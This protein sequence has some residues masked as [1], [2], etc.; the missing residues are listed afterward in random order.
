M[1]T[2]SAVVEVYVCFLEELFNSTKD[3]FIKVVV[4]VVVKPIQL[5][6][7]F[8]FSIFLEV[9]PDSMRCGAFH[10]SF[11]DIL[12]C[13]F[14]VP[15]VKS[16][17][18]INVCIL[19]TTLSDV[20]YGFLPLLFVTHDRF[21]IVL[22]LKG[23]KPTFNITELRPVRQPSENARSATSVR[24]FLLAVFRAPAQ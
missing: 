8:T 5:H 12:F 6:H 22:S 18:A 16:L 10:E 13:Y 23:R 15:I 21:Y 3:A 14:H 24:G 20:F 9:F 11:I 19:I 2:T 1:I 4:N 17:A 7:R